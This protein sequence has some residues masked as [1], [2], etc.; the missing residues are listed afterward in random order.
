MEFSIGVRNVDGVV[1]FDMNGRLSLGSSLL[2][3]RENVKQALDGGTKRLVL[4]LGGITYIDSSGLGELITT[5]TSVQ[6]RGGAMN[7]LNPGKRIKEL[8]QMTRLQNVFQCFDDEAR[9]VQ[10]LT[11]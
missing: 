6:N 9:S 8:L 2:L 3:L 11:R 7:L 1:V 5:H 10:E 4:N